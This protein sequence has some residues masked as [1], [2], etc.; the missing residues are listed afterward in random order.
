MAAFALPAEIAFVHVLLLM[1]TGASTGKADFPADR[2]FMTCHTFQ[3]LMSPVQLEMGAPIVV[4]VPDFPVPAVVAGC[5]VGAE[6]SL[7]RVLFL[8]AGDAFGFGILECRRG[9]AFLAF[10]LEM[11]SQQWETSAAMIEA[12][13]IPRL[14]VVAA[15]ALLALLTFVLIVSLMAGE[16]GSLEFVLE[17][18]PLMA[19][20][21]L[22]FAVFPA[23][24][25][26][27]IPVMIESAGFPVFLDMAAFAF[28]AEM[29]FVFVV[30]LMA[31]NTGAGQFFLV[32][33][34]FMAALTFC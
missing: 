9:M 22:D 7:M 17:K 28:L 4:E 30:L 20:D 25:I 5:A 33:R 6:T 2:L 11:S 23:K 15:L 16:T 3:A 32:A 34:S 21:A 26:L 31:A 24:R 27:G 13:L 10:D 12:G 19:G 8:V 29:P 1:A 18:T 14:L